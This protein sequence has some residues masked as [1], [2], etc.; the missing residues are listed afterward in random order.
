MDLRVLF[1]S[2]E[3]ISCRV[4]SLCFDWYSSTGGHKPVSCNELCN[5]KLKLSCLCETNHYISTS[6]DNRKV[7]EKCKFTLSI[8][9]TFRWKFRKP[10]KFNGNVH[11]CSPKETFYKILRQRLLLV[12]FS[13]SACLWLCVLQPVCR[14]G[15]SKVKVFEFQVDLDRVTTRVS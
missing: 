13:F 1:L 8:F 9:F 10:V 15:S 2:D 12:L 5:V 14:Y 7:T 11:L 6:T 4:V 3:W